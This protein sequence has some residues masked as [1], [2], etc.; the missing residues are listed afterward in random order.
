MSRI[1]TMSSQS[2]SDVIDNLFDGKYK[3]EWDGKDVCIE[4]S[5]MTDEE[6]RAFVGYIYQRYCRKNPDNTLDRMTDGQFRKLMDRVHK[7]ANPEQVLSEIDR[8]QQDRQEREAVGLI[9]SKWRRDRR[10]NRLHRRI[11]RFIAH[12]FTYP[13]KFAGN[14][15]KWVLFWRKPRTPLDIEQENYQKRVNA[16]I[17]GR[18]R[19]S[20]LD[21]VRELQSSPKH[22]DVDTQ[23]LMDRV[24]LLSTTNN[25][26]SEENTL[27]ILMGEPTEMRTAKGDYKRKQ[28]GKYIIQ[29]NKKNVIQEKIKG[30]E[31][32]SS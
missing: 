11:G 14:K 5:P 24:G 15:L 12:I 19:E 22:S 2:M 8:Q 23:R 4:D 25:H 31:E 18:S 26:T 28:N 16:M 1:A 30:N 6:I 20:F 9:I 17:S 29:E 21:M 32:E 10:S 7:G 3:A 27:T 13:I